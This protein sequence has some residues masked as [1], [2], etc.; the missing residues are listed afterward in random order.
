MSSL[1]LTENS[2]N[3]SLGIVFLAI[4][5]G[6]ESVVGL[7]GERLREQLHLPFKIIL[8]KA[9]EVLSVQSKITC[10]HP[11]LLVNF[12]VEILRTNFIMIGVFTP[13]LKSPIY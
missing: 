1:N 5:V 8:N 10:P 13:F 2:L 4:W 11:V 6:K 12:C 3:A 9:G 7:E